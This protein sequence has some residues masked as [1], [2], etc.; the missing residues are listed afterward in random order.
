[1]ED[2]RTFYFKY[3]ASLFDRMDYEINVFE[4]SYLGKVR[5]YKTK[6]KAKALNIFRKQAGFLVEIWQVQGLGRGGWIA[7]LIKTRK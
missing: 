3:K 5:K 2:I 6:S 7:R 4:T 1:V